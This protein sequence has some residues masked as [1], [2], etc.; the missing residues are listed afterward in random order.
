MLTFHT[1]APCEVFSAS[2]G[3]LSRPRYYRM[4]I[5]LGNFPVAMLSVQ[6]AFSDLLGLV[7]AYVCDRR[8]LQ[9]RFLLFV[10]VRNKDSGDRPDDRWRCYLFDRAPRRNLFSFSFSPELAIHLS[11]SFVSV[12]F[13]IRPGRW[14]YVR[15]FPPIILRTKHEP[16]DD[17]PPFPLGPVSRRC[18]SEPHL[19][20]HFYVFSIPVHRAS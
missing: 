19:T 6:S 8:F 4:K 11:R 13:P 18:F 12:R 1:K 10:L 14:E 9:R 17:R 2:P 16:A 3:P 20:S 15:C 5:R 7:R